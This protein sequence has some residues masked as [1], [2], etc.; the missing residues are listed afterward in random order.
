MAVGATDARSRSAARCERYDCQKLTL[1]LSRMMVTM[2]EAS[3]FSPSHAE[4]AR[5]QDE[6]QIGEEMRDLGHG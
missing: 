5:H 3:M 2:I 4:T 6:D 1:T